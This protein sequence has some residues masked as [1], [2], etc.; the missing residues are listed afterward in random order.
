MHKNF[1][2]A[3]LILFV[4]ASVNWASGE[5]PQSQKTGLLTAAGNLETHEQLDSALWVATSGEY[6]ACARQT[7]NM[8]GEKLDLALRDKTWTAS[9]EQFASGK[10][11]DLPPAVM[12]NL[13]ETVLNNSPYQARLIL[14]LGQYDYGSFEQ[15]R[16][17]ARCSAVPGAK[18]FLD[19]AKQ[20]HVA[21]IYVCP[22]GQELRDAT[23]RNLQR[24]TFPYDPDQDQ[25]LLEGEWPNHD[26]REQ[27]A[28][29]HRILL[30]I[31]DYLGD[32][33]HDT[34]KDPAVRRE[35]AARYAE[36]WGLKWFLVP[37]PMYGHWE[38]AFQHYNYDLD[39]S[40]RNQNKLRALE[41]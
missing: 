11:S 24:V 20:L 1:W 39:R 14:Q 12:V 19:R 30:I 17:E 10:Y 33:M 18:Q 15:W 27:V 16:K 29:K 34:A 7:F 5:E 8:A 25:L 35:M 4:L 6:Y 32:F 26:K 22:V 37:N 21:I 36:N 13:D 31:S 28:K 23:L 2:T 3:L 41:P 40:S 9:T 38:Y